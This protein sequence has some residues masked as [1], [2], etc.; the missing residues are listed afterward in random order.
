MFVKADVWETESKNEMSG[1]QVFCS[2]QIGRDEY[3]ILCSMLV[4]E[5][6]QPVT[7]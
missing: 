1:G 3:K 2:T 5:K 6:A 7:A 4:D